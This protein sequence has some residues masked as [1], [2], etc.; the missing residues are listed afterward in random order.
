MT[1]RCTVCGTVCGPVSGAACQKAVKSYDAM[2]WSKSGVSSHFSVATRRTGHAESPFTPHQI[3]AAGQPEP[4]PHSEGAPPRARLGGPGRH[5]RPRGT[6]AHLLPRR[7]CEARHDRRRRGQADPRARA[8]KFQAGANRLARH[9]DSARSDRSRGEN[10]GGDQ[11]RA[12]SAPQRPCSCSNGPRP[13]TGAAGSRMRRWGS[14][15]LSAA[16]PPYSARTSTRRF[17]PLAGSAGS[18]SCASP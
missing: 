3:S 18:A 10:C 17:L 2:T 7:G 13:P 14:A 5:V 12:R 1:S 9:Q 15:D 11:R 8:A 6:R 16:D 4:R